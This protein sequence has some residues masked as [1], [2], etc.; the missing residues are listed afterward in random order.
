MKKL[1]VSI[2]LIVIVYSLFSTTLNDLDAV[3]RQATIEALMDYF[4]EPSSEVIESMEG[5]SYYID[6]VTNQ[7]IIV[8]VG[9]DYIIIPKSQ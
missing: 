3:D 6:Q 1:L 8:K 2:L 4:N 7:Y 5:E 9:D